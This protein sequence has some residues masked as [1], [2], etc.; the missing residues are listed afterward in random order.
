MSRLA[1]VFLIA[2]CLALSPPVSVRAQECIALEDFSAG[3]VG[4]ATSMTGSAPAS[5]RRTA[6]TK[7]RTAE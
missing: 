5:T 6:M 3:T 2:F 1:F 7:C 4:G